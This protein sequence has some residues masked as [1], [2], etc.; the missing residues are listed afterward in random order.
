M[1][2]H[3]EILNWIIQK[4]EY[5]SYL[6]IGVHRPDGNFNLIKCKFKIGV[7]PNGMASFTGTSDEFFDSWDG[8]EFD[9]IF[10]DGLHHAEQVRKDFI[11]SVNSLNENGI[12]VLHDTNPDSERLAQV[13][14]NG[15]RGRWNGDV[16]RV[17]HAIQHYDFKTLRS[18]PNGL[19][20]VK[21]GAEELPMELFPP[22]YHRFAAMRANYL[23]LCSDQEFKEWI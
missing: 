6:E 20:V 1:L 23:Q 22:D 16:Y 18:E 4:K 11:H 14:R 8:W 15:L 21:N 19:T 2:K 12:I 7:D 5:K 10:I 9:L 17:I 13:P 3:T